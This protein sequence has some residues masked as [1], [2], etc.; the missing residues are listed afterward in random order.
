MDEFSRMPLEQVAALIADP[1]EDHFKDNCNLVGP[2]SCVLSSSIVLQVAALMAD[3]AED[4][5][6]DNCNLVC[7]F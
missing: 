2:T 6:K 3:P 4:Q 5:F 1:A 7:P